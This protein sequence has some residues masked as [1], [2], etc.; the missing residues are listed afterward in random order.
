MADVLRLR[1]ERSH[2][3]SGETDDNRR[4]IAM[5]LLDERDNPVADVQ[6]RLVYSWRAHGLT[7]L[8]THEVGHLVREPS[9]K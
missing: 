9:F 7:T 3:S 5:Q 2:A 4:R 1:E 8:A 6:T